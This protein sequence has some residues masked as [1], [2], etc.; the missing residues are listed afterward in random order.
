[1]GVSMAYIAG[2]SSAFQAS[3]KARAALCASGGRVRVRKGVASVVSVGAGRLGAPVEDV[4]ETTSPVQDE[5]ISTNKNRQTRNNFISSIL[6]R[7]AALAS[8]PFGENRTGIAQS[9]LA[10][11]GDIVGWG[12]IKSAE[13]GHN[14]AN[15]QADHTGIT[16]V[17]PLYRMK[18]LILNGISTG[19]IKR[20]TAGNVRLDFGIAVWAHPDLGSTYICDQFVCILLEGGNRSINPVISAAQ[21]AQ[22][23]ARAIGVERFAQNLNPIRH[24]GVGCQHYLTGLSKASCRAGFG[25]R[26]AQDI[27]SG[28]FTSQRAFIYIHRLYRERP[29]GE[30]KQLSPAR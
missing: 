5:S 14:P 30:L 7:S 16:A 3:K 8:K 22:H 10:A 2:K 29:A 18:K 13:D 6:P 23:S 27:I 25:F 12:N 19:L 21:R 20:V 28:V 26:Q 9:R 4:G 17:D 15:G 24:S 1:M 11:S